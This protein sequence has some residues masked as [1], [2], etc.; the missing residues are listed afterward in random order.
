MKILYIE[1]KIK[2]AN[3]VLRDEEI[4]KLPNKIFLLYTI[5]YK[6]SLKSIEKQLKKHKKTIL[7][8]KQVLGCSRIKVT[9]P[10][11]LVGNGRF[12]ATN[13]LLQ[14]NEIYILEYNTIIRVPYDSI[15]TLK[16]K[17]KTSLIKFLNANNI[18]IIVS[19]KPGQLN[20]Q[21]SLDIANKLKEKLIKKDKN[22]GIFITNNINLDDL[23][24]YHIDSW[25]NLACPGLSYDDPRII[26]YITLK[27]EKLI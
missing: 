25:I 10:V 18:G 16:M 11:L 13:L 7:G 19:S 9:E 6:D 26:N 4:R 23:D 8:K 21:A 27:E 22:A 1:S 17:L 3:I 15:N 2:N 12:H 5:Q 20:I 14:V 24:N